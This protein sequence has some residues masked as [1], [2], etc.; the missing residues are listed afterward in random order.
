[1]EKIEDLQ[2]TDDCMFGAVM[3]NP[4]I[5]QQI[6]EKVLK[7]N[8]DHIEYPDLQKVIKPYY[9]SK[10]VRL[11]VYIRDSDKVLDLEMQASEPI[12]IARRTRYYQSMVDIDCLSKG[13]TYDNLPESYIVFFCKNDYLNSGLSKATFKNV[14]REN[15]EIILEDG[16]TKIFMNAKYWRQ[17]TDIEIQGFLKYLYTR[18]ATTDLTDQINEQVELTKINELFRNDYLSMNL[19]DFDIKMEGIKEGIQQ[20]QNKKA[21]ESATTFLKEGITPEVIAKC[22]G[23]PLEEV[24][25]LKEELSKK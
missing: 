13:N 19:H 23:L 3:R 4:V 2:F 5:C 7:M 12:D 20:G 18:K 24:I 16:C 8:V 10:G 21:W 9:E 1:M 6:L 17:E 11:D 15:K 22:V 25:K 14:C